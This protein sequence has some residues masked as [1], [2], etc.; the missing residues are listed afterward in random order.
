M[1][2]RT[3]TL[4][5]DN[6]PNKAGEAYVTLYQEEWRSSQTLIPTDNSR[7]EFRGFLGDYN[8]KIKRNNQELAE[9]QFRLD[10][11]ISFQCFSDLLDQV[12]CES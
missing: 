7:V 9:V 11:D 1:S 4:D 12:F 8:V 6:T 10:D 2:W 3:N 5:A